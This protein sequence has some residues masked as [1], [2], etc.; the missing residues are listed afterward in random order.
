[1]MARRLQQLSDY[2]KQLHIIYLANDILFK[3]WALEPEYLIDSPMVANQL[4]KNRLAVCK[5]VG[6]FSTSIILLFSVPGHLLEQMNDH[7][8]CAFDIRGY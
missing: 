1:M 2:S 5:S 4:D 6:R 3:R 8:L 7:L